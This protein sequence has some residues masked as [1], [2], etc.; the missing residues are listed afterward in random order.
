MLTHSQPEF[1]DALHSAGHSLLLVI[2]V[3]KLA[4]SR[5]LVLM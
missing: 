3:L 4:I 5:Y 2:V 1:A